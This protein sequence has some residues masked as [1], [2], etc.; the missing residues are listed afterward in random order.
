[1]NKF[2][3][4]V[5]YI[6][7]LIFEITLST[8]IIFLDMALIVIKLIDSILRNCILKLILIFFILILVSTG[9]YSFFILSLLL[10]SM[11]GIVALSVFLIFFLISKFGDIVLEYL[12]KIK[13]SLTRFLHSYSESL[14]NGTGNYKNFSYFSREYSDYKKNA[15]QRFERESQQYRRREEQR[16]QWRE[17]FE[18]QN[19]SSGNGHNN[20][21]SQSGYQNN[22]QQSY[23]NNF[24][25]FI[26]KYERSCD[27]MGVDY[28]SSH[29]EIKMKF[30]KLARKYHPD[31]NP[32]DDAEEKFKKINNAFDFLTPENIKKYK[33]IKRV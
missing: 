2:I 1:M 11:N 23:F 14:I 16:Q 33:E 17:F 22:Y 32:S 28:R 21:G 7:A 12:K 10:L 27:V 9:F 3:G 29:E 6:I 26:M 15:H 24:Q 8:L 18:Q 4:R 5:I 31:I 25:N 20:A 30:R 13:Y 19:N